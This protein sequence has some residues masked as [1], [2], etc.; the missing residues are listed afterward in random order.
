MDKGWLQK[1]LAQAVGVCEDTITGWEN[2]RNIPSPKNRKSLRD[3][4]G[5]NFETPVTKY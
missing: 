3:Q 5:L 1:D 4:L 2:A